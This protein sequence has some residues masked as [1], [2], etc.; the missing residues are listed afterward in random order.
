MPAQ[1]VDLASRRA[2][3]AA[4]PQTSSEVVARPAGE[5]GGGIDLVALPTIDELAHLPQAEREE[6]IQRI[7]AIFLGFWRTG[8]RVLV[9]IA[10]DDEELRSVYAESL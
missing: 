7:E 3:S 4:A 6:E 8:R 10:E 2:T 5:E 1:I 9:E